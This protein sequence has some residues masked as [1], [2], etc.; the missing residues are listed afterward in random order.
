MPAVAG[1][2]PVDTTTLSASEVAAICDVARRTVG[3][4]IAAG[5]F[6]SAYK[7]AGKG[8]P[9]WRIPRSDVDAFLAERNQSPMP[10]AML[11]VIPGLTPDTEATATQLPARTYQIGLPAL[12]TLEHWLG[13]EQQL[14]PIGSDLPDFGHKLRRLIA[15]FAKPDGKPHTDQE[16]GE[17]SGLSERQVKRLR[18]GHTPDPRMSVV[19]AL[20][21]AFEVSPLYFFVDDDQHALAAKA[22]QE[23]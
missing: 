17:R 11:V 4:W 5:K 22:R 21:R 20:S 14:S 15:I 19:L 12:R 9:R 2:E 8:R 23:Q 16:I 10:V 3:R 6:P 18:Y 7:E 13:L 1:G